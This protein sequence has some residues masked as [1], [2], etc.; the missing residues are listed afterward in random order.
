MQYLFV[1]A[2]LLKL[3]MGMS[4]GVA[5]KVK[6]D[7]ETMMHVG[8]WAGTGYV[9]CLVQVGYQTVLHGSYLAVLNNCNGQLV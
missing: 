1:I 8:N 4:A 3:E 5:V 9:R 6:E 7:S 2:H